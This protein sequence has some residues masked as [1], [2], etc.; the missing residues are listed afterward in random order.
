MA[1]PK[2]NAVRAAGFLR[3]RLGMPDD[4]TPK[5]GLVLGTGWGDK[6]QLAHEE[7][8]SMAEVLR[9][10]SDKDTV[11]LP[12]LP[13]H[14]RRVCYGR[15]A[16]TPVIAL[17][18]RLHLFER[19]HNRAWDM[20]V[21][22]QVEM[23]LA[24]GVRTFILTNA[25]GG[26][27]SSAQV[28]GVVICD[29]FLTLFAPPMPLEVEDGYPSPEDV[30]D[31]KLQKLA[32]RVPMEGLNR[33]EGGYAMVR[34]PFF[35]GRAYDKRALRG[36]GVS[37]VGMSTVP[38]ASV[39]ALYRKEG[40]RALALS[41]ITNNAT[42]DHSHETNVRRA[43]EQGALLSDYLQRLILAIARSDDKRT[44]PPSERKS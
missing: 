25:A 37:C 30:L 9:A 24:L 14:Q 22:L 7:H 10:L 26:L 3:E 44:G 1:T 43:G 15:V 35:E 5:V 41:F 6:L 18:G 39:I 31:P 38:E 36:T 17:R 42:E 40:A 21:R 27:N 23:L 12:E 4:P 28:G 20:A 8:V 16:D 29:G 34:G 19:L 13:G 33:N 2:A 32:M 11:H